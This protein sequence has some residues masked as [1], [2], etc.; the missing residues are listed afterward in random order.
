MKN[1]KNLLLVFAVIITILLS[2]CAN[3]NGN[4]IIEETGSIRA[5]FT[6]S[7]VSGR[8]NVKR[9]DIYAWIKDVTI[10]AESVNTNYSVSE[11]Y[12]LINQDDSSYDEAE[13][14]F[15]LNDVALGQNYVSA[16]TTT[17]SHTILDYNI[18]FK[19]SWSTQDWMDRMME[20]YNPYAI[21]STDSP[22]LVNVTS[23]DS[24]PIALQMNTD[25]SRVLATVSM[26][27]NNVNAQ[28][29]EDN[30]T[31]TASIKLETITG[32]IRNLGEVTIGNDQNN[33][34]Q[35]KFATLYWS[36]QESVGGAKFTV[37]VTVVNN[38]TGNQVA[39]DSSTYTLESSTNYRCDFVM[40]VDQGELFRDAQIDL[41]WQN[42]N[43]VELGN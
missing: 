5:V 35:D 27:S 26:A 31:S 14:L 33:M 36:N 7:Q 34:Y 30:F 6:S 20:D 32:V 18:G 15:K 17:D 9:G 19:S 21:Y 29:L 3:E 40:D 37:T 8:S 38:I 28:Y 13:D 4:E 41:I 23:E 24:S 43:E 39:Q 42:W 12:D 11:S 2:S 22:I 25:N 1:I 16:S 10:L